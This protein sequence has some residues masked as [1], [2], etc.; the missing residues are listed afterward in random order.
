MSFGSGSPTCA[1]CGDGRHQVGADRPH[2]GAGAGRMPGP[3]MINGTRRP[4]SETVPLPP[5]N[6]GLRPGRAVVGREDDVGVVGD[7][8][9]VE[10]LQ[11]LAEGDVEVQVGGGLAESP[12]RPGRRPSLSRRRWPSG[13]ASPP[14]ARR[15]ARAG[16]RT[17]CRPS[18][19]R[20][21]KSMPR[22]VMP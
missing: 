5:A 13:R 22:S 8:Q 7:A 10:L 12:A 6:G 17:A 1:S 18:T 14:C 19:W 4:P 15:S 3:R 21:M 20:V 11:E 16:G 9:F 2:V